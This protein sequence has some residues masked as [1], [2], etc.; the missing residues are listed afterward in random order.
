MSQQSP[1]KDE[2]TE[3]TLEDIDELLLCEQTDLIEVMIEDGTI[4]RSDIHYNNINNENDTWYYVRP[5]Y[6]DFDKMLSALSECNITH[7]VFKDHIWIGTTIDFNKL[8][9]DKCWIKLYKLI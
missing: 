6:C 2:T 4:P 5:D 8:S 9:T 7:T 1:T 3:P